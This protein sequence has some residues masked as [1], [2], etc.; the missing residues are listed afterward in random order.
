MELLGVGFDAKLAFDEVRA[1]A[2]GVMANARPITVSNKTR[3]PGP[4]TAG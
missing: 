4:V 1:Q 3:W 2:G